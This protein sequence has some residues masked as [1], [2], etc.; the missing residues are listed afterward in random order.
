[1]GC[2]GSFLTSGVTGGV[3]TVYR[4]DKHATSLTCAWLESQALPL[5]PQLMNPER[6]WMS[7]LSLCLELVAFCLHRSDSQ[8]ILW[9]L[10]RS[11]P[12]RS[13]GSRALQGL[14]AWTAK[15][16]ECYVHLWVGKQERGRS[17]RASGGAWLSI[18][19][20]T[21]HFIHLRQ[22]EGFSRPEELGAAASRFSEASGA[23]GRQGQKVTISVL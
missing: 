16:L 18:I 4:T 9:C 15:P 6:R 23:T 22:P 10:L 11:A 8:T 7:S 17:P 19:T 14:C 1:M 13:I 2:G 21:Q 3:Q 12:D 5:H 20:F